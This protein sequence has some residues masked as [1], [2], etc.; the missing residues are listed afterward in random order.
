MITRVLMPKIGLTM[1]KGKIVEWKK[2]EEEWVEKGEVLFV[3]ET[4]K[5]TFDGGAL[6]LP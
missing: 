2:R 3:F 1:T 4:E 5:V 6:H